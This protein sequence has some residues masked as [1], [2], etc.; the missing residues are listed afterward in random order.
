[1]R[2]I[3]FWNDTVPENVRYEDFETPEQLVDF[4]KYKEKDRYTGITNGSIGQQFQDGARLDIGLILIT[5]RSGAL[6]VGSVFANS[7]AK[8]ASI[9]RGDTILKINGKTR[10]EIA[11]IIEEQPQLTVEQLNELVWGPNEDG[12]EVDLAIQKHNEPKDKNPV[13]ITLTKTVFTPPTVSKTD[14]MEI[15][16]QKIGYLVF[17]AFAAT[18]AEELSQSFAKYKSE[19]VS[20][21]IL[22]LR[23][24]RGGDTNS[25]VH[26]ASLIWGYN[27]G[28][29]EFT[30]VY[31][32]EKYASFNFS[33]PFL[34]V[35]NRLE[36]NRVFV[37]TG[38]NTASSSEILINNLKPYMEVIQIGRTTTGKPY[39]MPIIP[40]CDKVLAPV[41]V[42]TKNA[43][44]LGEYYDGIKPDCPGNDDL[45]HKL[46]DTSEGLLSEALYFMANGQCSEAAS[47]E[48]SAPSSKQNTSQKMENLLRRLNQ[49]QGLF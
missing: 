24:N 9:E 21:L 3:Y 18:S 41:T 49:P 28:A 45:D 1:M 16:G 40:F 11:Q 17:N 46:G 8:E 10:A 48:P 20:E 15:D 38:P 22:D 26:L 33:A 6:R 44:D 23:Y 39:A 14:I 25:L 32:N 42:E 29:E 7:S 43:L 5:D 35:D 12:I 19:G 37:L 30:K 34:P 47:T 2:D 4:L 27:S 36:L 31:F 13:N